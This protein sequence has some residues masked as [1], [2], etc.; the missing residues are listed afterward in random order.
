[1][2]GWTWLLGG[3]IVWAIH[4]FVLYGIASIW[5]TTPLARAL[6]LLATAL[7]LAA[8]ALLIVRIRRSDASGEMDG[9]M[10]A[11]ALYGA[12]ISVVAILWQALPALLL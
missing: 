7:C 8:D 2:R 1:V 6:T 9:W 3:L 10:R 5:L 11:V 4:F 12:A